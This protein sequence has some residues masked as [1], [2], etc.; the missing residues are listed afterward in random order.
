VEEVTITRNAAKATGYGFESSISYLPIPSL[1][2]TGTFA[3]LHAQYDDFQPGPG[4]DYSGNDLARA[5]EWTGSL[6]GDYSVPLGEEYRLD[7][8]IWAV[9]TGQQYLLAGNQPA[10]RQDDFTII[11]SELSLSTSDDRYYA[12]I[13]VTNAT[14]E[15]YVTQTQIIDSFGL[16]LVQDG[17]PRYYGIR[18]GYR[19]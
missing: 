17:P 16:S 1:T 19:F 15:E 2:L 14:D 6:R 10:S 9:Y 11:N 8:G 18:L 12:A 3:W 4:K 5:P 13:F 7:F